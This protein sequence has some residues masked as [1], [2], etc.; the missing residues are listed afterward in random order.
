[1]TCSNSFFFYALIFLLLWTYPG[2]ITRS[3]WPGACMLSQV[4]HC[5]N[6]IC[7]SIFLIQCCKHIIWS[8]SRLD[9]G[10][11]VQLYLSLMWHYLPDFRCKI[12]V[13]IWCSRWIC[14]YVASYLCASDYEFL[15][16]I[17]VLICSAEFPYFLWKNILFYLLKFSWNWMKRTI[18][19][20]VKNELFSNFGCFLPFPS[21]W[22]PNGN[23]SFSKVG[24][25][26]VRAGKSPVGN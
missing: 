18:L 14:S 5:K 23:S 21:F 26:P 11:C 1:M 10:C 12:D 2:G 16:K 7:T 25:F 3:C 24:G 15:F 20:V 19:F 22:Y 9:V 13:C 6:Y 8:L 17:V 4:L